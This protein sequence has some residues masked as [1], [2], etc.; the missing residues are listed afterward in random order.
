MALQKQSIP[1]NFSQGLDTK[2]D[3]KQVS[4]GKFLSLQNTVFNKGGLLQKRNGYQNL[5]VLPDTNVN[6]LTTFNG[7]LTAVG[8]NLQA[9][10]DGSSQWVNKGALQPVELSTMALVRS[11][12]NQV[13][14]DTAISE[15]NLICTVYTDVGPSGTT[16]KYVIA[17]FETGQNVQAPVTLS[18]LGPARVFCLGVFFVIVYSGSSANHLDYISVNSV[19]LVTSTAIDISTQYAI[20]PAQTFDGFVANGNLYLAWKG[21]DGGRAIRYTLLDS[22]LTLHTTKVQAGFACDIVSMAIDQTVSNPVVYLSFEDNTLNTLLMMSWDSNLNLIQAPITLGTSITC[23][24]IATSAYAGSVKIAYEQTNAYGYDS[25]LPTNFVSILARDQIGGT[26][27]GFVTPNPVRSIG[28]ASKGFFYNQKSYFVGV[29]SSS[30]QPTYFLF[31]INTN[32]IARFAY[33]NGGGYLTTGLP[34]VQVDGS[35][36]SLSYQYKDL[37]Q[38]VN[39]D[40]DVVSSAG[41][42]TQTGINLINIDI[43]TKAISTSEIGADLQISGGF[44]WSYDGYSAVENNFFLY[45]DNVKA[46]WNASTTVTPT[47]TTTTGSKQLTAVSSTTGVAVGMSVAGAGIP[48]GSIITAISG[49]VIT[50]TKAATATAT[51]IT[52]TING[53]VAAQP[54]ALTNA[55]AY[56]YQVTYEWTDNQGNLFRSS[57]SIATAVTTTG[58]GTTGDITL[59]IPTL[60]LTYK[61]ANPV[62]IVVYRWSVAHQSFYQVTSITQP[63]LN[64]PTIDYVTYVD[65]QADS[66]IIGNELIYTTGGVVEDVASP[67][68]SITTLFNSRLF[69]VDAEDKNLLWY[70]KQVVEATPV[71]MSDLFTIYVAPTTGSQGSTGP[72]T[73]LSAMDDKLIIFKKDAIYY[74]TGIGPDN[75]GANNDFSNAV[76]ITGTVGCANQQSIVLI[77]SGIMFQSD[78]GIWILGRDLSTQYIGAP[79]EDFNGTLVN[80]A[81]SIPETNQVRFTLDSGV[82]LMYDYFY[83]QWGTFTN[84]PAISSTLYQGVHTFVNSFGKVYQETPG[85]YL[86]GSSP[87]LMSLK[88]GWFNAAGLQGYERVYSFYLLGQYFTPHFIQVQVAYDYS[89]YPS[90]QTIITPNNYSA[91]WGGGSTWG[92]GD[93]WGGPSSLEQ[94]Q[95]Y[96]KR[97]LCQAFQVSISE[98]FDSRYGVVAGAGFT[99]S[100]I[101]MIVG[102]KSSYVPKGANASIG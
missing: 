55:S 57:P 81:V 3:P 71:E 47:G 48:A 75:T 88:T 97:Q 54:D 26:V 38:A 23:T 39:K 25:T 69:L 5:T 90:Q 22:T 10:I 43:D 87:V 86:D 51:A 99:M 66:S 82:T 84:V 98:Q 58:T 63:L 20:G 65:A 15:N 6:L 14:S 8:T 36:A 56:F 42:Y 12:T 44:L 7:N 70:S 35:V 37:I 68:T 59:N 72:I 96:T 95:V 102:G 17:D 77:P 33:Q 1:I 4:F 30:F 92:S 18:A 60:R 28:L 40:A 94:W 79:V 31:D 78:K 91:P 64:D 101:N 2:T 29:Y 24:N 21:T 93:V 49:A 74:L 61:I 53:N 16:Y 89:L 19:T 32:I 27:P 62:K 73:A 52:L 13:Q 9:Y 76:F 34:S 100:G 45:P 11:N 50:M 46:T 67:G 80:S 41:I 85:I 83:G